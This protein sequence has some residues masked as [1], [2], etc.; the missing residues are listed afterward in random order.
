MKELFQ[1]YMY[2][3][4][5]LCELYRRA[6]VLTCMYNEHKAF[7]EF[8]QSCESAM[9]ALNRL[10]KEQFG[11]GFEP[12]V[13]EINIQGTY[14]DVLNYIQKEELQ[15]FLNYRSHTYFQE[16]YVVQE[17]MREISD[18]KLGHTLAVLAIVIEMDAPK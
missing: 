17:T 13:S 2:N 8:A 9:Q 10:Y 14:R 5:L 1:S 18:A 11:E 16:D 12:I 7:L 15:S 6:A 3:E 4:K